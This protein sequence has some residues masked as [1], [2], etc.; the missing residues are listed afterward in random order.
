MLSPIHICWCLWNTVSS[1]CFID[2]L[3]HCLCTRYTSLCPPLTVRHRYGNSSISRARSSKIENTCHIIWFTSSTGNQT[4]WPRACAAVTPATIEPGNPGCAATVTESILLRSRFI[5]C[6]KVGNHFACSLLAYSGTTHPNFTCIP[7]VF[8]SIFCTTKSPWSK[9]T[10]AI[11]LSS[12]VDS[13]ASVVY[14][15]SL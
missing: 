3:S 7:C 6:I 9:V 11:E 12:Q 13:M 8:V 15:M 5:S 2:S 10:S 4:F 14:F 1:H